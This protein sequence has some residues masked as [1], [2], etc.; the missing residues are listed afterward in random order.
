MS[1]RMYNPYLRLEG[2][3]KRHREVSLCLFCTLERNGSGIWF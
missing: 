2:K 3:N 1:C